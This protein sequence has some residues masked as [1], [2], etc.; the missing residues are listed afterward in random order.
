MYKAMHILK[1]FKGQRQ[2][3]LLRSYKPRWRA[4]L[5][6]THSKPVAEFFNVSESFLMCSS[7]V[8]ELTVLLYEELKTVI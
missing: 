1:C 4:N 8:R 6:Q 3:F 7:D 5:S 2:I